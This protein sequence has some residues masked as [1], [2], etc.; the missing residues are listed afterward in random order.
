MTRNYLIFPLI[1]QVA[2]EDREAGE[3]SMKDPN[4]M[5]FLYFPGNYTKVLTNYIGDRKDIEYDSQMYV[6]L[7]KES[8]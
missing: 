4:F 6:H 5:A 1:L 8:E 7:T 2:V 3:M